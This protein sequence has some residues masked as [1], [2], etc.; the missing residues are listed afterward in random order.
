MIYKIIR[1]RINDYSCV[2]VYI[3]VWCIQQFMNTVLIIK[4]LKIK[5]KWSNPYVSSYQF[6]NSL[7]VAASTQNFNFPDYT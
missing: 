6:G 7:I 5:V 4:E 1:Y 2:F 3:W